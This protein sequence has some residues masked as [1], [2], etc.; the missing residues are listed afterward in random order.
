MS[1]GALSVGLPS[2]A[3]SE[4]AARL[5][6]DCCQVTQGSEARSDSCAS[7][8]LRHHGVVC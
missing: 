4:R 2:S 6:A 3:T 8:S 5:S 7:V 1:G